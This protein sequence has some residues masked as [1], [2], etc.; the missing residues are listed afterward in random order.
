M[1]P[2]AIENANIILVNKQKGDQAECDKS[3]ISLLSA[4]GK[5]LAKIMLTRLL[6]HVVDLVLLESQCRFWRGHSTIDIFVSR[7]L[8]E[9]FL[10]RGLRWWHKV[11]HFEIR[12]RAGIQSIKYIHLHCQLHWLGHIIRM[13]DSRLPHRML[14][15]QL[16]QDLRS[17]G[18]QKKHFKD[19][20]KS[21]LNK[22]NIPFNS[23]EA[24]ASNRATWRSTCALGMSCF[25][26]EYDQAVA[27]RHSGRH[28]HAE[29][30]RPIPDS[31]H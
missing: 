15:G 12:S 11:T 10:T 29:V 17:I 26:A 30:H 23:L 6:E 16:R 13:P 4:A 14:H 25:D 3:G 9:K 22:Y 27:L 2:T 20:I 18:G 1:S 7:Q 28:Q 8:Q 31:V 21:I 24:P 19:H 5:V